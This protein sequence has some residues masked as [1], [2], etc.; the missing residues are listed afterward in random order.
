MGGRRIRLAQSER[1]VLLHP[2]YGPRK[3]SIDP[4]RNRQL[5]RDA[6]GGSPVMSAPCRRNDIDAHASHAAV[7]LLD[8]Y[9]W[10]QQRYFAG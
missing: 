7:F 9:A 5:R 4:M 8:D 2:T 3:R 6:L 1:L 10:T